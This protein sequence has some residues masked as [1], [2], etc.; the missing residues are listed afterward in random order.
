MSFVGRSG[1][2]GA[3]LDDEDEEIEA[4][5]ETW[6]PAVLTEQALQRERIAAAWARLH[7]QHRVVLSLHEIE[8]YSLDEVA[9]IIEVAAGD[10]QIPAASRAQA[11]A[12]IVN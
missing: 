5:D 3:L 11:P 1:S 10:G 2:T 12:C 6:D 4:A 9:T 7:Q 8:G